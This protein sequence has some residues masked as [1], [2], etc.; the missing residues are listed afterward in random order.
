MLET[1]TKERT[2][3]ARAFAGNLLLSTF[4]AEH[5]DLLGPFTETVE[6]GLGEHIQTR[7]NDVEWSY[8]PYETTMISLVV[9]L[10][11]GRSAEVASIGREG[12]VGG[13]VSCGHAPAFADAVV[14]VA[15]PAARVTMREVSTDR[16]LQ[17]I[18][19]H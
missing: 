9:R 6:L 2:T 3:S 19:D 12:A 18:C 1:A 10:T 14:H 16:A 7:G 13:I 4:S 15:G 17:R 11:D 8:F 5:R